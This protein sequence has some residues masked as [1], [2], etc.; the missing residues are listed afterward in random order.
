MEKKSKYN[1]QLSGT[2]KNLAES[3]KT[4][5]TILKTFYSGKTIL[6]VINDQL[7]TDFWKTASFFNLYFA[8]QRAPIENDSFITTVILQFWQLT[9]GIKVF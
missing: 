7:M 2:L 8:K 5:W 4:Y 1:F 3:P 9:L 6:L